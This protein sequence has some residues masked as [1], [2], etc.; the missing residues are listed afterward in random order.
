MSQLL[1][2][3]GQR[4]QRHHCFVECPLESQRSAEGHPDSG[5]HASTECQLDA[6][7]FHLGETLL[8]PILEMGKLRA[9]EW[10]HHHK[11]RLGALMTLF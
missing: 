5:E 7:S 1:S 4:C 6:P 11:H 2:S 9:M 8:M 3:S 10:S